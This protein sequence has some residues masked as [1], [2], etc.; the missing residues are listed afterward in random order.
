MKYVTDLSDKQ[1]EDASTA[2]LK[3]LKSGH[4]KTAVEAL[5]ALKGVSP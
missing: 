2:S 3:Q 1:V 5:A 4:V